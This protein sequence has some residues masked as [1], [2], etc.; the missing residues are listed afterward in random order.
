[1]R[2]AGLGERLGGGYFRAINPRF[3]PDLPLFFDQGH[4]FNSALHRKSSYYGLQ[5]SLTSQM[6]AYESSSSPKPLPC[7]RVRPC[8][9]SLVDDLGQYIL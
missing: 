4:V 2:G 6:N 8:Q 9:A 7:C 5:G 1:M 3:D